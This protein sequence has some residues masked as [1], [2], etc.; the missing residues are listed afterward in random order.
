[1]SQAETGSH[2]SEVLS[3]IEALKQRTGINESRQQPDVPR[4][5][6]VF[7]GPPPLNFI[8]A[9]TENLPELDELVSDA[10]PLSDALTPP[11][12]YA[13]AESGRAEMSAE[14]R[15]ALLKEMRPVIRAAVKKAVLSEL[16]VV[17]KALKTTL[18]Q[19]LVDALRKRLES[20]QF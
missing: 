8:A 3:R 18:E 10:V 16:A 4:L 2:L 9:D 5:T 14:Q 11:A 20:N 12:P 17:E 6:E 15:E 1:M 7:D 19:D 13:E